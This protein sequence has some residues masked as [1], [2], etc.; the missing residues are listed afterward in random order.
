MIVLAIPVLSLRLGS[1]D[2]GNDP[3]SSTTRQAYDLLAEGF[4]PGFNGPLQLVATTGSPAD[5][6]A[7]ARLA[8]TLRTEPGIAAVS[9][10]VSGQG[11]TLISV[12]P[13]TSPEA[14]AT[15]TPHRPATRQRDPRRRTRHLAAR[16]RRRRHRGLR[17]F[18]H[19]DRR[20]AAALHRGHHR[21]G[22]PAADAGVPQPAGAR[23]RRGDEPARCRGGLRRDG[24]RLPVRLGTARA[25]PR[26]GRSHRI[27]P[28]RA[29]ARGPV[30]PVHGLRGVPGLPDPRGMGRYQGQ[31]PGGAAPA[32]PPPA[33]SS[34]PPPPS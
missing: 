13:T 18:R 16:L 22:V 33:G 25:Q 12:I 24:R 14:A 4:G 32:R 15:S 11:A 9:A 26:P 21:A 8:T 10:P 19:R 31:P 34:S 7:L 20:Q 28:A 2:A 17:R 3:A 30:R 6:A 5:A 1:S 29:H 27:V 23:R